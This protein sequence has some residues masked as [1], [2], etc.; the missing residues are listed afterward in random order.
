MSLRSLKPKND[1]DDA[2]AQVAHLLTLARE[3]TKQL[4]N[5]TLL[6]AVPLL[7]STIAITSAARPHFERID[8]ALQRLQ[9]QTSA[10]QR[11]RSEE[12]QDKGRKLTGPELKIL[13]QREESTAEAG[14]ISRSVVHAIRQASVELSIPGSEKI[15]IPLFYA[16]NIL[17]LT[18]LVSLVYLW[19]LRRTALQRL[20]E[21]AQHCT[22][23]LLK[24]SR[25]LATPSSPLLQPLPSVAWSGH[26][27][28]NSRPRGRSALLPVTVL[29]MI[30]C[31]LSAWLTHLSSRT[32]DIAI[33]GSALDHFPLVASSILVAATIGLSLGWLLLSPIQMK[34]RALDLR[35]RRS[36]A[37][38]T[39]GVAIYA[40]VVAAGKPKM[41]KAI[42]QRIRQSVYALTV[43]KPRF[44]QKKRKSLTTKLIRDGF[45]QNP[46]SKK[47]H[48]VVGGRVMSVMTSSR[49]E[50]A[51]AGFSPVGIA[52]SA[53]RQPAFLSAKRQVSAAKV[54]GIAMSAHSVANNHSQM[55]IERFAL[56]LIRED[57]KTAMDFLRDAILS[58]MPTWAPKR[59]SNLDLRLFDLYAKLATASYDLQRI[60]H[61]VAAIKAARLGHLVSD[62]IDRWLDPKSKWRKRVLDF[63][64]CSKVGYP[65]VGRCEFESRPT[66]L[67]KRRRQ[68]FEPS[69]QGG[70]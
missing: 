52:L 63:G 69:P 68:W 13:R 45:L 33:R 1:T 2:K 27:L 30:F 11:L 28:L 42:L 56:D 38:A 22:P 26:A 29:L 66:G 61:F 47:A 14:R 51:F 43:H 59:A 4:E 64:R 57:P 9:A 62:R 8:G 54:T 20:D 48:V 19:M 37:L 3:V 65:V 10:A 49:Q 21:A 34:G 55:A 25:L 60:E 24:A 18:M 17:Q 31:S 41:T 15:K 70:A 6:L 16:S 5:R 50:Q 40:P 67:F 44:R 36:L 35:A 46:K 39:L 7:V 32:S 12:T 23:S 58:R 53:P